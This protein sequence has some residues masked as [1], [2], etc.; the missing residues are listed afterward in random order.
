M[1]EDGRVGRR[2][3]QVGELRGGRRRQVAIEE[4]LGAEDGQ[5]GHKERVVRWLLLEEG[6]SRRPAPGQ[7]ARIRSEGDGEKDAPY[8]SVPGRGRARPRA[9]HARPPRRPLRRRRRLPRARG[10]RRR[11]SRARQS[12]FRS[13][14][15]PRGSCAGG[16]RRVSGKRRETGHDCSQ[17]K[18]RAACGRAEQGPTLSVCS[19]STSEWSRVSLEPEGTADEDDDEAAIWWGGARCC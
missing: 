10:R 18:G 6:P 3:Q 7:P 9:A 17:L 4:G 13:C 5:P 2:R 19:S 11:A 16:A 8:A 15:G 14:A 1:P 12:P